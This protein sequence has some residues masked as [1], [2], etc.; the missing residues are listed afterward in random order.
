MTERFGGVIV[1]CGYALPP[2]TTW[3]DGDTA[4]ATAAATYTGSDQ[5]WMIIYGSDDTIFPASTTQTLFQNIFSKLGISS[6]LKIDH[7]EIGNAHVITSNGLA[8]MVRFIN[9][10]DTYD[11]ST[12]VADGG[13][14]GT[15]T[16]GDKTDTGGKDTTTKDDTTTTCE[17]WD[18]TCDSSTT[19]TD[20]KTTDTTTTTDESKPSWYKDETDYTVTPEGAMSFM[21]SSISA[22]LVAAIAYTM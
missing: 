17:W 16:S 10:E 15:D 3:P 18:F 8:N 14:K 22:V 9:G 11:S 20:D 5:R 12:E 4:T 21:G 19:T 6:V 2:S 13:S 7:I 1:F